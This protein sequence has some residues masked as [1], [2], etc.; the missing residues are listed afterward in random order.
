MLCQIMPLQLKLKIFPSVTYW[1]HHF[2][3]CV[4]VKSLIDLTVC[5][6][7]FIKILYSFMI[8][9]ESFMFVPL[10]WAAALTLWMDLVWTMPRA[11]M[12]SSLMC[13]R[14]HLKSSPWV[15]FKRQ[16]LS[17]I[18]SSSDRTW[19]NP[20][21]PLYCKWGDNLQQFLWSTHNNNSIYLWASFKALNETLQLKQAK[22]TVKTGK[23]G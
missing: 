15:C 18:H 17:R 5:L 16:Y 11:M 23:Y 8:Q 1:L 12:P 10:R 22:N 6:L 13:W 7:I 14:W 4:T 3:N 9:V 19:K 21:A 20:S 2:K